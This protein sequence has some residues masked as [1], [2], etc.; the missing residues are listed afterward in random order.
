MIKTN[1]ESSVTSLMQQV[2]SHKQRLKALR[3][4]DISAPNIQ[5]QPTKGLGMIGEADSLEA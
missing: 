1:Y 4:E 3:N 5:L 2:E